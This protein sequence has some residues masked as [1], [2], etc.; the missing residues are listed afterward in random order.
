MSA[1]TASTRALRGLIAARRD[2]LDALLDKYGA[3]NPRLFGPVARGD[4]HEGSDIDI[5]VDMDPA[6]GNVFMRASG[7]KGGDPG[8][9]RSR[10]CRCLPCAAAEGIGVSVCSCRGRAPVSRGAAGM[11]WGH[12]TSRPATRRTPEVHRGQR[13][14]ENPRPGRKREG[15]WRGR[16]RRSRGR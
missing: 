14:L 13:G 10:R 6:D 7:L 15:H 16:W 11:S 12:P 1:E 3:T 9:F 5:L 8:A 4:A 2:E